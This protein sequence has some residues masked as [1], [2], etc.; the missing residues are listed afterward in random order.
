MGV[1]K[2]LKEPGGG[3][4]WISKWNVTALFWWDSNASFSA[5][6]YFSCPD[7][8]ALLE[9]S[10]IKITNRREAIRAVISSWESLSRAFELLVCQNKIVFIKQRSM[11]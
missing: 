11:F 10:Q 8:R 7:L 6:L 9:L 5:A 2:G 4:T 3:D 1:P